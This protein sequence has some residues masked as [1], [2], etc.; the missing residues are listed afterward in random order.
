MIC[1]DVTLLGYNAL[2]ENEIDLSVADLQ[3]LSMLEAD[4]TKWVKAPSLKALNKFLDKLPEIALDETPF[5]METPYWGIEDGVDFIVDEDGYIIEG[6]IN[7]L[8]EWYNLIITVNN[9]INT[10]LR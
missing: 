7:D 5:D 10:K 4:L 3:T 9:F 8:K 1:F 2:A 6:D